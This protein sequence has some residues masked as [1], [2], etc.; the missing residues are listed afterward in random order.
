MAEDGVVEGV[1]TSDG[2]VLAV[3]WHP[4]ELGKSHPQSAALFTDL[5]RRAIIRP[6]LSSKPETYLRGADAC[7]R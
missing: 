4:E 5:V 3:Q 7:H 2:L 6:D 1:E